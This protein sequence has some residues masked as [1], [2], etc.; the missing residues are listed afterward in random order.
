MITYIV[1]A[2]LMQLLIYQWIYREPFTSSNEE[3]ANTGAA[4]SNVL[5]TNMLS[6]NTQVND[7]RLRYEKLSKQI[8]SIK[9]DSQAV[10]A[11]T[12]EAEQLVGPSPIQIDNSI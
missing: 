5:E 3:E 7:L 11:T 6:I 4:S 9:K 1:I 2:I 12:Q 8:Q 10:A